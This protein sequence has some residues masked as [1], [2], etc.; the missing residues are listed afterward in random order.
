LAREAQARQYDSA[1]GLNNA[2]AK[3][4]TDLT[5][6][7]L[8]GIAAQTFAR[9]AQGRQFDS[10]AGYNNARAKE[11]EVLTPLAQ[12][13]KAAGIANQ[14]GLAARNHQLA[15]STPAVQQS[16]VNRNNAVAE[17]AQLLQQ[18]M[19]LQ[20]QLNSL[21]GAGT[22]APATNAGSDPLAQARAAIAKGAD[23]A[24]VR[25]RLQSMGIDAGGL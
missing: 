2:R 24:K 17:K 21:L 15:E 4:V 18:R 12:Q 25:A 6:S 23:P 3:E 7:K 10:V 16:I 9:N 20:S 22:A 11:V 13:L 5:P 19:S 14:M 1:A 8:E